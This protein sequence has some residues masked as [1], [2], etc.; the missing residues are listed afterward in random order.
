MSTATATSTPQSQT[1]EFVENQGQWDER[2]R[3]IAE[4]PAGRLFIENGG[5]TYAWYDA[6]AL[7]HHASAQPSPASDQLRAHALRVRFVGS[8][9]QAALTT[10]E[11][12]REIR[13]YFYGND[14]RKWAH[15]VRGFRQLRY[16]E[17]W[18][19]IS[20]HLYENQQQKLEYDF[21]L[22]PAADPSRI[23]LRY[24]G[25]EAVALLPDGS[26]QVRTSLGT[27]KE[28]APQA[29]QT[30]ATGQRRPVACRYVL[31]GSEV[32]FNLGFYDHQRPLT[33]DPTVMYSTY[34]GATSDNWGFTATY[35]MQ[36]NLY[37]GGISFG[38][39][40]P[41]TTGAYQTSF[42]GVSD[43]ALIKYNA[44]TTGPASRVW[45]TYIGGNGGDFPHSLV[46]NNQNELVLLG[47]TSSANY[48]TA[49]NAY[50]RSFN[51]GQPITPYGLGTSL[52][53]GS[54]IVVTRLSAEG[55]Q[56]LGSTYLGGSN[57]D[58]LLNPGATD[59]LA[60]NYG[61][62]FR[63]DIV[64]D[65]A[66]S[67]YIASC[68]ASTDFPAVGGFSNTYKGGATDALICKLSPSLDRLLWSNFLGG[69]NSDGAY[70]LQLDAANSLYVAG[71]TTSVN[72]PTSATALHP[73][74]Q[75][76]EDGFLA[77]ISN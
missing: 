28:L 77:H 75:G 13:N 64:V 47:S 52:Q 44:A 27:L 39:G 50:D 7:N 2:A 45:A 74:Y 37:S 11:Q 12:T 41:V 53:S 56:L 46:V 33:I 21:E 38:L 29:W 10:E 4:L 15:G 30:D 14:S 70:S 57:N 73:S 6:T 66:G 58:G 16:A 69:S 48:P 54:D 32:S 1:L 40:Y 71:G 42:A 55:N 61:D 18:P 20:A 63:G 68:T 65:A 67:I 25:G 43:I 8:S 23:R 76:N 22:A 31:S 60:R 51:G 49:S 59:R 72:F 17:L 26:L 35:D 9:E 19:G 3:Y 5:L 24:E 62:A 36:G 34:T